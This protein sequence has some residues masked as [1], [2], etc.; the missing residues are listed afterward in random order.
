MSYKLSRI[1]IIQPE[2]FKDFRGR[3]IELTPASFQSG[4]EQIELKH[5]T[6]SFSRKNVLRG[7]H[8]DT[9]TWKQVKVLKGEVFFVA[10]DILKESPDYGKYQTMILDDKTCTSVLLPPYMLN[11][12]YVLSDECIFHYSLSHPYTTAEDQFTAN[13]G[14]YDITWPFFGQHPI[15]SGRD[16]VD[17]FSSNLYSYINNA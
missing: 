8:G 6:V 11:G 9:Q 7:L 1:E 12:H 3:N 14:S 15:L 10:V 4:R 2:I 16:S 5:Q 17:Q 13:Y